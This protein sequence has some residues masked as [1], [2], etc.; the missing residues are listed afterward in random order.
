[1]ISERAFGSAGTLSLSRTQSPKRIIEAGHS[2]LSVLSARRRSQAVVRD[3]GVFGTSGWDAVRITI[4]VPRNSLSCGSKSAAI[5]RICTKPRSRTSM[6][7]SSDISAKKN[8]KKA[9]DRPRPRA[10]DRRQIDELNRELSPAGYKQDE[11]TATGSRRPC[12]GWR[13]YCGV[14]MMI[15]E[16]RRGAREGSARWPRHQSERDRVSLAVRA[17]E[18]GQARSRRFRTR[19]RIS[20]P[21]PR[22]SRC[23]ENTVT[24]FNHSP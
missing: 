16:N 6:A 21:K 4:S 5:S 9:E 1:V 7:A 3:A 2:K 12:L 18:Q 10:I 17:E 20:R 22:R 11:G 19:P 24:A 14:T 13:R 15:S 8:R 23:A